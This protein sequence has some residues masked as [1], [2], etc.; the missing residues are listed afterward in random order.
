MNSMP[1]KSVEEVIREFEGLMELVHRSFQSASSDFLEGLD[2]TIQQFIVMDL[3]YNKECPK[4]GDLAAETGL[5]MSNMTAMTD[6]LIEHNYV[7][8]KD[9]PEDRRVVRVCLTS[10]AKE[11]IKKAIGKKRKG[12]DILLG[13]ISE[14]D[15]ESLA[16]IIGK[17]SR[18][19]A[20]GK[21]ETK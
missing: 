12:L 3:I 6:R 10:K 11:L 18:A 8:R 17:M 21:G 16:R 7:Q 13:K 5:T 9:D 4:M 2:I 19:M 1:G 20:D 15:R 14:S